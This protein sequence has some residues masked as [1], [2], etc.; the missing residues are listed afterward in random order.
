MLFE[1]SGLNN[2][3][4]VVF[5]QNLN[6]TRVGGYGQLNSKWHCPAHIDPF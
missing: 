3:A 2:A 5:I 1:T 4:H 6:D